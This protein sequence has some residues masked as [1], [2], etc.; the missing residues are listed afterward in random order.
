MLKA[1]CAGRVNSGVR[2]LSFSEGVKNMHK[3]ILAAFA[4]T[5]FIVSGHMIMKPTQSSFFSNFSLRELV[6]KNESRSGLNCSMGGIGGGGGGTGGIGRKEFHNHKGE[7]FS[8]RIKSSDGEQFDEAEFI[9]SLKEDVEK[10]IRASG[11]K[12]T[13][14]GNP[15]PSSFYFEYSIENIQGRIDV[16]GKKIREDYYSLKADIDEKGKKESE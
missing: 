8:C 10:I 9:V 11:A 7:S 14:S 16:S 5:I 4:I 12:V 2:L 6:Q 13:D 3:L 1:S 15:D